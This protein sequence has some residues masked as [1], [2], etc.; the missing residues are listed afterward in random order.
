ML[1]G[2]TVIDPEHV[3]VPQVH[4]ARWPLMRTL[5]TSLVVVVNDST[6]DCPA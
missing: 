6:L 2:L 1:V 3:D 5:W 4:D